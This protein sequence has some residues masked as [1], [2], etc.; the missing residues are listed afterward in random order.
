MIWARY[1]LCHHE[2]WD[3]KGYPLG[4]KGEQIPLKCRILALADAYDAMTSNRPYRR[5]MTQEQA[6]A[7]IKRCA[8]SQFDPH[9]AKEFIQM[10]R[11]T[12]DE[13]FTLWGTEKV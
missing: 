3:G 10:I 8:G 13:A 1:V 7:E 6:L 4:L 12:C 9:L 11:E 5:A 2:R